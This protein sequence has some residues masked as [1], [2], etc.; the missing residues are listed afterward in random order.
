MP[1]ELILFLKLFELFSFESFFLFWLNRD[2]LKCVRCF[3]LQIDRQKINPR[4]LYTVLADL[5]DESCSDTFRD[6]LHDPL[7]GRVRS[8]VDGEDVGVFFGVLNDDTADETSKVTYMDS[9]HQVLAITH[10]G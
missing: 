4:F 7:L 5:L 1:W 10:D 2:S 8:L 9:R 3:H 6:G